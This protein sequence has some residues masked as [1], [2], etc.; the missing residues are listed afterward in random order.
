MPETPD[1]DNETGEVLPASFDV[2]NL[3]QM[4]LDPATIQRR[5]TERVMEADSLEELFDVWEAPTSRNLA[6]RAFKIVGVRWGLY[7][8]EGGPVPLA[9][10][11]ALDLST[12]KRER[13]VTT[14]S[15]LTSFL[16]RAHQLDEIPFEAR[17]VEVTTRQGR[18]ALRFGRV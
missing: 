5:I 17:I 8:A 4:D 7:E 12:N 9:E 6:N 10:V 16:V 11:D 15:N 18:T 1:V 13:F 14:A 3:P 2:D